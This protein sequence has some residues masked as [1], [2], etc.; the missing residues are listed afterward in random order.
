MQILAL[1]RSAFPNTRIDPE[2]TV[3]LWYSLYYNEDFEVAKKAT[4]LCIRTGKYF[5]NHEQFAKAL[6]ACREP[7]QIHCAIPQ[8]TEEHIQRKL[9]EIEEMWRSDDL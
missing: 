4:E 5:P 7:V 3:N 1:L 2:T 9:D 6:Y 8:Y